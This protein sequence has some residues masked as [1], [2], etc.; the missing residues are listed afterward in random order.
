MEKHFH[1]IRDAIHVFAHLDSDER[2]VVDSAPLQRLRH[3][4]QLG[5]SHLVYPGATHR[6][7]EHSLGVMELVGRVFDVITDDDN[8]HPRVADVFPQRALLGSWRRAARMAGL[9][10]DIGHLPF[11]HSAEERLLPKGFTHENL[12]VALI[13]SDLMKKTWEQ[14][15]FGLPPRNIAKLAMGRKKLKQE[16]YTPWEGILAETIVGD[17]FG[18]DRMDYLLRD[19]LHAGVVYGRIDQHRLIDTLRVLPES[20][21]EGAEAAVGIEFGGLPSAEGLLL[22]RYFMYSQVYFHPIRRIYDIHLRDFLTAWL[23]ENEFPTDVDRFLELTDNEVLVEMAKAAR[24]PSHPGHDPADRIVRHKHFRLL[25]ERNPKDADINTE[26]GQAVYEGACQEFGKEYFRHDRH[27]EKG[28]PAQFPVRMRDGQIVSSLA[29]SHVLNN[30]PLVNVD[31]V[32]VDPEF[33]TRAEEW[34]K[35][36]RQDIIVRQEEDES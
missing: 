19:S 22:A 20:D 5:L 35:K 18:V 27:T 21:Q 29:A 16:T 26:A 15:A 2:R 8:R 36:N 7:F 33:R 10:H 32:F 23:G 4:H 14:F 30:L 24:E 11:S 25:Y 31:Y 17:S 9:C 34:L 1:E 12:G 28:T 3:I 13:Q 6:R